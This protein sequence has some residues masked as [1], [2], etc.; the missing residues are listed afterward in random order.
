MPRKAKDEKNIKSEEEV[1]EKKKTT[2]STTRKTSSKA[3]AN[4][5][6]ATAKKSSAKSST[7]KTASAKKASKSDSEETVKKATR[8]TTKKTSNS[9]T[10]KATTSS[11]K[12]TTSKTTKKTASTRKTAKASKSDKDDILDEPKVDIVE[13]YDLPYRYNQTVVKILAQT[14]NV[15][16][17]YWDISDIDR[18]NFINNYGND[19]FNN[20]V[21]ILLVINKTMNY[22]YEVEINDFAN[23]WYL[24]VNDA[25]CEY[26]VELG[27]RTKINS[28]YYHIT[29]S[30]DLNMPN[31]HIL[32]ENIPD[33][34]LFRNV[35][36]QESIEKPITTIKFFKE[37]AKSKDFYNY[38]KKLLNDELTEDGIK[39]TLPSSHTSSSFK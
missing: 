6:K 37:F 30:N 1:K 19:F 10:P 3:N 12:K 22:S 39:L 31:D 7:T 17:V 13:Y 38:F 2:K 8:K 15:L 11:T 32:F 14:P 16:F 21:P 28:D 27:R 20:T 33:K 24:H 26:K 34:V 9:V 4:T 36:T 29:T 25:N 35:K 23:S 5:T 18:E